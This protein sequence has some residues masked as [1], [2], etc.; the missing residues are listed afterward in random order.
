MYCFNIAIY[1]LFD[2]IRSYEYVV[3]VNQQ[4][5]RVLLAVVYMGEL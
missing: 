3:T 5:G 1:Y 2:S 4:L